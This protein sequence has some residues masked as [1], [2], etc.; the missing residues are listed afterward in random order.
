MHIS[1]KQNTSEHLLASPFLQ[2]TPSPTD[3]RAKVHRQHER[4]I[5]WYRKM[6]LLLDSVSRLDG[7]VPYLCWKCKTC[8]S[9][10]N[11]DNTEY[12]L[13]PSVASH[14][15]HKPVWASILSSS[16]HVSRCGRQK[17]RAPQLEKEGG[18][19]P[20]NQINKHDASCQ[21]ITNPTKQ[22]VGGVARRRVLHS[23]LRC[24]AVKEHCNRGLVSVAMAAYKKNLYCTSYKQKSQYLKIALCQRCFRGTVDVVAHQEFPKLNIIYMTITSQLSALDHEKLKVP[25]NAEFTSVFSL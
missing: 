3:S 9:G 1:D 15:I 13:A 22:D 21:T 4:F 11:N 6:L 24:S 17:L 7:E 12:L 2:R 25:H 14:Q 20:N 19:T 18:K 5:Y 16:Q 23:I 10:G 8:L